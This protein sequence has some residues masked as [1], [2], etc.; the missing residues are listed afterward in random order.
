MSIPNGTQFHVVAP[1][2]PTE[3]RGSASI[4]ARRDVYTYPDDFDAGGVTTVMSNGT[5]V[6]FGASGG[7]A[8]ILGGSSVDWGVEQNTAADHFPCLI[9]PFKAKVVSVGC[10]WGSIT[11]YQIA[12]GSS[13]ITFNISEALLGSNMADAASW[14]QKGTLTTQWDGASGS[15]PGFLEENLDISIGGGYALQV[16]AVASSGF[17]NTGEEVELTIVFEKV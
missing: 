11:D 16:T 2:V 8:D 10:Q 4:N 6:N 9:M 13:T 15:F 17:G 1:S 5:F 14:A 7:G 3:N 12:R